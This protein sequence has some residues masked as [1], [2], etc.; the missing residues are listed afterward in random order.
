MNKETSYVYRNGWEILCEYAQPIKND[1]REYI[2]DFPNSDVYKSQSGRCRECGRKHRFIYETSEDAEP[3]WI[4]NDWRPYIV[5][6]GRVWIKN[7][8]KSDSVGNIWRLDWLNVY[9]QELGLSRHLEN[10]LKGTK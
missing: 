9:K 8:N 7:G 1:E 10:F 5:N 3:K 2:L 4:K 6:D